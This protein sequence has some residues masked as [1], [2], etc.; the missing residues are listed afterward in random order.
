M[1]TITFR[2]DDAV[3]SALEELGKGGERER[4]QIIREAILAAARQ[5]RRERMRA[6]ALAVA[7][8]PDDLAE[9]RRVQQEMDEIRAW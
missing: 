3:D 8:D 2:T 6:E 7:N 1:A 9:I 5:R 4:S